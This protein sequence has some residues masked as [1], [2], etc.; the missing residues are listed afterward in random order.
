MRLHLI[1]GCRCETFPQTY[2]GLPLSVHK[3][4]AGAFSPILAKTDRYLA[5]W[6][7]NL[8]NAMGRTVLINS[9][10]DSQLI[11]A[12]RALSLPPGVIAQMD[13]RRL[14]F[15]W[16]GNDAPSGAQS[17]VA[18]ER[19]CWSKDNGRLGVR[20]LNL[21]NV[22][23][24]VKLLHRLFVADDSAWVTWARPL[25][26]CLALPRWMVTCVELINWGIL[27]SLLPLYQA[28]TTVVIGNDKRTSL[29]HDAWAG[30]E[31]LVDRFPALYS[32][33][34]RPKLSVRQSLGGRC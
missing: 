12:M 29:W 15:L 13:K 9:V 11:Y 3:L 6:Q 18:W 5:G 24:L 8:L 16:C 17:L 33:C 23:L 31:A 34:T 30:D 26:N 22:C 25:E 7:A 21:M 10:L 1:L 20:D 2:L 28:A 32:H 14:S 4:P 19:V 27:R